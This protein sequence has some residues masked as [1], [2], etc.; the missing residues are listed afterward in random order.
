MLEHRIGFIG[1]GQMA[2]ALAKGFVRA[3]LVAANRVTAS[4]PMAESR[5]RFGNE[6]GAKTVADNLQVA[7]GADVLFLAVKPQQMAQVL[8]ELGGQIPPE[9]LVVSIA[10]GMRL[11]ALAEGL[12]HDVRLVRVMPNTP[13][14]V[15]QGACGYCLGERA[16]ADDDRLVD[17]LLGSV[18]KAFRVEEKLLDAV[19]GLSGSGPAFVYVIIEALSDGGV[20]M[21]LPRAVSSAL[22]AQ[23][24]L[25]AAQMVL[26]TAEHPAVLKDRVTSPGGTTIAGLQALEEGGLRAALMAAVEEATRRSVELGSR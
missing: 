10:A 11:S 3:G 8:A 14:L 4:D 23:T 26:Q 18:G 22:A 24:V 1:A 21:G 6:T 13:C 15:G 12:G 7:A 9:K 20:R 5:Q 25:G 19:T 16:T 17:Q 2:T